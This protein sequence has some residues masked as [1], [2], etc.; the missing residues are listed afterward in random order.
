MVGFKQVSI[1]LLLLGAVHAGPLQMSCIQSILD[2]V[3][4][5]G[6]GDATICY[7]GHNSIFSN[8]K[9]TD[10][11]NDK[12]GYLRHGKCKGVAVDCFWI[13]APNQW[14][15]YAGRNHE[16]TAIWPSLRCK[17]DKDSVTLTCK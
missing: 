3:Q 11:S 13:K 16:N 1:S 9:F 8:D 6:K 17:Y 15:G 10:R 5:L 7:S 14:R 2:D 4:G 12:F